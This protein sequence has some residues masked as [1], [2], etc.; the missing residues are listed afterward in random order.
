MLGA[1][2]D[3]VAAGPG[4]ND[5]GSGSAALIEIAKK[6]STTIEYPRNK[7]R[8]AWWSGEEFNL[9]GSAYY[10]SNLSTGQRGDIALYL[11]FDMIAS[12][13]FGRFIYDGDNSDNTG[14]G[15]GPA[16][17][18]AIE[19]VFTDYFAAR[20][21]PT[22]GTDFDGRSDYGPFIAPSVGIPSGGIFTGAEGVKTPAQQV[23]V[24]RHGRRCLRPVLP[25]GLRQHPQ[26]QQHRLPAERQGGGPRDC[27]VRAGHVRGERPD[28]GGPRPGAADGDQ[29]GRI[30][31][32]RRRQLTAERGGRLGRRPGPHF[33]SRA[34]RSMLRRSSHRAG[35]LT[36][37]GPPDLRP[38]RTANPLEKAP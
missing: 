11:N 3:S 8:F 13:N 17:S 27:P 9:L 21:L 33:R 34:I 31:A 23:E 15:P 28:Q 18:A 36:L 1:H 26:P 32:R 37:N 22:E 5:N 35:A 20:G 7:V 10:V 19:K 16:G 24:R 6:L 25:P 38:E 30:A 12:P 2:L 29:P 14:A 4:I